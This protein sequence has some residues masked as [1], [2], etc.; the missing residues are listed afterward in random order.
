MVDG[1]SCQSVVSARR[2]MER[3][4][5]SEESGEG[6]TAPQER[7]TSLRTI[8]MEVLF[9]KLQFTALLSRAYIKWKVKVSRGRRYYHS[10]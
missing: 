5:R 4:T 7:V 8:N 9:Y 6:K 10:T 3:G 1:S 2:Q